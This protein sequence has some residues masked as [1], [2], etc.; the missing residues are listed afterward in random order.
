MK[1]DERDAGRIYDVLIEECGATA[2][3]RE[4]C[5]RYLTDEHGSH[6]FR[7]QGSLGFGGKVYYNGGR[8]YVSCYPEDRTPERTAMIRSANARLNEI[9]PPSR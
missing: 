3:H 5:V 2:F 4:Q 6:E 9:C 7:F 1:F 8:L